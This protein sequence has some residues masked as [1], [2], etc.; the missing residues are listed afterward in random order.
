MSLSVL[1]ALARL[2]VDPW[3][4]AASLAQ[5]PKYVAIE[6]MTLLISRLP[7]KLIRHPSL[8]R[9]KLEFSGF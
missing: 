5:A 8:D 2:D 9:S 6:R 3:L 4:E 1:S 7:E